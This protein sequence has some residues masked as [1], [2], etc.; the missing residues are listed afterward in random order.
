MPDLP[1]L[2]LRDVRVRPVAL[3][4]DQA[5]ETAAG[6]V[7]QTCLV[8]IDLVTDEGVTGRSYLRS[9][10]PLAHKPLATLVGNIASQVLGAALAPDQLDER[11]RRHFAL[12]GTSGLVGLA[13][14]ALEPLGLEWVEE[15]TRSEDLD[16][17]ARIAAAVRTPVQL[18]ENWHSTFDVDAA[19]RAGACQLATFDTA[20]IGGVTGWRR[21]LPATAGQPV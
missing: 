5:V 15:P 17:H 11:V 19:A 7:A 18:G 2:T 21:C 1:T 6:R 4:P 13:L 14:A 8:L 20:R 10:S 16:G 9:Y 3:T 12:M